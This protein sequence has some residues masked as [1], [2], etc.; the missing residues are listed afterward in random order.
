MWPPEILVFNKWPN[1]YIAI[2]RCLLTVISAT[3]QVYAVSIWLDVITI[4]R[5][6]ELIGVGQWLLNIALHLATVI[7]IQGNSRPRTRLP[8]DKWQHHWTLLCQMATVSKIDA[9]Q[10]TKVLLAVTSEH[11]PCHPTKMKEPQTVVLPFMGLISV[12]K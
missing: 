3:W 9:W 12:A 10:G 4:K 6:Q 2:S 1:T 8:C 5:K 7:V 11:F